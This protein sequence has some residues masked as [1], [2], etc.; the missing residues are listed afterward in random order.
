MNDVYDFLKK[1]FVFKSMENIV[2]AVSGGPDSMALLFMLS[3]L[4]K[5]NNIQ[6]ICAHV[7]HNVRKE[8]DS[9]QVF[10]KKFCEDN[11]VIFECM[12]INEYSSENFHK[13]ARNIRYQYFNKILKKYNSKYLFT[14][15]HGDDLVE[16]ILMRLVR[17]ASMHGYIGFEKILKKDDYTVVRP[18][19]EVTKDD[20]YDFNLKNGIEY[21]QDSSN[22]KDVYTRNR[23]R[24]YVVPQL[25]KENR[26]VH[27][28]FYKFSSLLALYEKNISNQ[29]LEVL[30]KVYSN[31]KIDISL[32]LKNDK[33]IQMKVLEY[34]LEDLYK[35]DIDII[36]DRH[37]LLFQRLIENHKP[38]SFIYFP[39][40]LVI[41]KEYNFIIFNIQ[42]C[43]EN[44]NQN[45]NVYFY[46]EIKLSNGCMIRKISENNEKSNFICRL[47]FDEVKFPLYV[48]NRKKGDFMVIKGMN[49]RKKVSDIFIDLKIPKDAR[50]TWPIV[51]DSN[52]NI[53]WIPGLKKSKFDKQ[54]GEKCDIILKCN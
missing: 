11:G 15:H 8:S 35:E 12:K 44:N 2:I 42:S 46:D 52:D 21:V 4:Q 14:A 51:F 13:E 7:N 38:N 19:I 23:F 17:G 43:I 50:D 30:P 49:V 6:V 34:I 47:S 10:V 45:N 25:K 26:N 37:V 53:I 40:G 36:T 31:G 39:K 48:R 28:K 1:N 29:V 54:I 5:I 41:K 24:K 20:I 18:F 22:F 27:K 9:E 3:K 16:T 33:L 32:F